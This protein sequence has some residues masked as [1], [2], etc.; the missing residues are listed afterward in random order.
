MNAQCSP[1]LLERRKLHNGKFRNGLESQLPSYLESDECQDGWYVSIQYK[2]NKAARKRLRKLP[3]LVA[4]T[5]ERRQRIY[6]FV[7]LMPCP[8]LPPR[9]LRGR[10]LTHFS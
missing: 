5:A 8:R 3:S 10:N 1:A 2:D 4:D 6:G 7:M 9:N